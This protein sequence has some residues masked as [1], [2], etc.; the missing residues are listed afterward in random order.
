MTL[1]GPVTPYVRINFPQKVKKAALKRSG[2][3]C[4]GI[5]N[6]AG[7]RCPM[8]FNAANPPEVD[9]IIEAADGGEPTL[10]NAQVL[11]A[12]CCHR[13]KT[14]AFVQRI[15]KADRQSHESKWL[16][17]GKQSK[18]RKAKPGPPRVKQI[19]EEFEDGPDT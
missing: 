16:K 5:I 14:T 12:K 10:E 4:E 2:G 6:D 15:R 18:W 7:E 19:H 8:L 1:S 17:R 9:H 3:R 11:G 13:S